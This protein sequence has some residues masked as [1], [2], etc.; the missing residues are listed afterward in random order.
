ML[1]PKN[2]NS[3]IVRDMIAIDLGELIYQT[4]W[5]AAFK[6]DAR[7]EGDLYDIEYYKKTKIENF[8]RGIPN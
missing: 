6:W 4:T 7:K 2:T 5:N 1:L 3:N 8:L